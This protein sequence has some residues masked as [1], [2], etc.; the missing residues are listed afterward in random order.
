MKPYVNIRNILCSVLAVY[1]LA[2]CKSPT[3][4]ISSTAGIMKTEEAFFNSVLNNTFQFNTLSARM[5]IEFSGQGKDI[6]SRA[7]LKMIYDD[8]LQISVQP[9]LG[10]EMF[11]IEL[12]NDSVKIL[13]RMNKQYM[14]DSYDNINGTTKIDFNFHNLQALFTNQIFVPGENKISTNHFRRFR[15]TKNDNQA[16]LKLKDSNGLF[17]TFTADGDEKLLSVN[18]ENESTSHAINW[19]YN[20]FQTIGN[21]LFPMNMIILLKSDDS[22]QGTATLS[23]SSPEI[24]SQLKTE[25]NIPSGFNKVTPAQI[26]KLLEQR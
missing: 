21:Q 20:S 25:F 19:N 23:F 16:L 24:N 26:L 8:R 18:I 2:A 3:S 10:I 6:S 22:T 13:D 17:Y 15:M 12:T 9:F 5:K 7:Q 4:T 1:T 11:R 14:V